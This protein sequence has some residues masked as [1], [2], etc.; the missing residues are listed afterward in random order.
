MKITKLLSICV[1][2]VLVA[3]A[4]W[5]QA[6]NGPSKPEILGYLDPHTGAFRP[7]PQA[8]EDIVD[9]TF[10]TFTGTITVTLTIT[11]KSTGLTSFSCTADVGVLDQI[12]STPRDYTESGTAAATG[13]GTTRTCKVTI[14]YAWALG[15]Q[16]SDT[17]TTSYTVFA[18]GGTGSAA[19]RISGLSPLD[20]RKVPANGA[21]T[22]LTANVTI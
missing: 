18:T 19:Q 11:V 2:C 15:T 12:S 22:A 14:P 8:S 16:A 9:A 5:G 17:M 7:V 13:T 1:C 6:A 3:P 20:S 10:T 21:T 4:I